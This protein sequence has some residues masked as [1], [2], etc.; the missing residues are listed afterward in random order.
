[1]RSRCSNVYRARKAHRIVYTIQR[2]H[3][4][5]IHGR[6]GVPHWKATRRL[7]PG[8]YPAVSFAAL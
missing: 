2:V 6:A 1:M 4:I 7:W 5:T 3:K 8:A